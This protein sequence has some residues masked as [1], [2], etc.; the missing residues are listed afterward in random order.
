MFSTIGLKEE[1]VLGMPWYLLHKGAL[2]VRYSN[3]YCNFVNI[4][5]T[6]K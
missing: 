2:T 1:L 4:I 3:A 5:N 6:A